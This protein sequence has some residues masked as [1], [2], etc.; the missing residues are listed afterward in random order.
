LD[1]YSNI[2]RAILS[3]PWAI[4][5]ESL[6]WAAMLDVLALRASGQTLSEVEITARIEA[7]QNGPREGGKRSGN[8][9]TVAVLP[10]YGVISPRQDMMSRTS[11]GTTASSI[12]QDF[13][14]AMADP[15]IDGI[16][17][18]VDSPGGSVSGI[19]EL[20]SEIRGAR[21]IKPMAA[22]ANGMAASAAYWLISGVDELNVAP[23]GIVG[24]IG[25]FAAHQDVS[26]AQEKLGIK[27]TLVSAGKYKVEG[28]QYAP[29]EE[30]ARAAIQDDV[31]AYYDMFI[32]AVAKGRRIGVDAVRNGYGEG[33]GVVAKKALAAGMVDQIATLDETIRR[34]A[35]GAVGTPPPAKALDRMTVWGQPEEHPSEALGSRLPFAERLALVSAE[36]EAI[37]EHARTRAALRAEEGRDLSE[38]T[39]EGLR[40]LS[41]TLATL[42]A[43]PEPEPDPVVARRSLV[44]RYATE[45]YGRGYPIPKQ[46]TVPNG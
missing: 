40:Q 4:D 43:E 6:A 35:R 31:D 11:G 12:S 32:S 30:E 37:A 19:E 27:T 13:R 24:S 28:N 8:R 41:A 15:E 18:D 38:S 26:A 1:R 9:S 39:R 44:P 16:V 34:V 29:L 2:I 3:R 14:A 46:E 42:A 21:G 20:A 25:V 5:P 10:I 22:V 33:R 17:F 36:A 45:A 23:S 7:A